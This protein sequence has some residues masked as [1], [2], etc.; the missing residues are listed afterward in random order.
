[1]TFKD[2]TVLVSEQGEFPDSFKR[3][4]A[5]YL[6]LAAARISRQKSRLSGV[7]FGANDSVILQTDEKLLSDGISDELAATLSS[8]PS[9]SPG[10]NTSLSPVHKE[11]YFLEIMRPEQHVLNSRDLLPDAEYRYALPPSPLLTE[12]SIDAMTARDR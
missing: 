11:W 7:F 9:H 2:S 4:V 6:D 3:L 10:R 12:E 5:P 8:I 1:M